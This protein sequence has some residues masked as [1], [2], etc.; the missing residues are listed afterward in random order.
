MGEQINRMQ[1][2]AL[3]FAALAAILLM[4]PTGGLGEAARQLKSL[5][6]LDPGHGGTDSG[7]EG[8]AGSLEKNVVL[9]FARALEQTLIPAY[10]VKMTRTS[11]YR[12]SQH[13]RASIANHAGADLFISIHTGGFFRSGPEAWGLYHYPVKE[14][15]RAS[16]NPAA[17]TAPWQTNQEKA[18]PAGKQ[19]AKTVSHY[20]KACPGISSI[21]TGAAPDPR[22]R[23]PGNAGACS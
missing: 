21:Q 4:L 18:A 22:P 2:S 11:D 14:Q 1:R 12:I 23:G 17:D 15:N 10:R 19:M 6:V 20:L 7:V 8:M 13:K 5:I 9:R 3:I 16:G